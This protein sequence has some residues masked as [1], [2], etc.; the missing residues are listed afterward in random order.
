MEVRKYARL[1]SGRDFV[2]L[3]PE[4]GDAALQDVTRSQEPIFAK[5]NTRW[6]P[7]RKK[8]ARK[9]RLG[10]KREKRNLPR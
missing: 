10:S 6:R 8:I 4:M 2:P 7:G 3:C 9:K 1:R 5:A